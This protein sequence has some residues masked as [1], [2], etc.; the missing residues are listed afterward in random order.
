M[1]LQLL[2][3]GAA[4][5]YGEDHFTPVPAH[6]V[7]GSNTVPLVV[8]YSYCKTYSALQINIEYRISILSVHSP[9]P[10]FQGR[11]PKS[12][13][14]II[15]MILLEIMGSIYSGAKLQSQREISLK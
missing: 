15:I 14:L 10:Y 3:E 6:A 5:E 8:S 12:Q 7:V 11:W 13:N 9:E 1:V 2:A 4:C